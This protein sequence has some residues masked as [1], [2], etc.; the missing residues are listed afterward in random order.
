MPDRRKEDGTLATSVNTDAL[1][2]SFESA[3]TAEEEEEA[4]TPVVVQ[5]EIDTRDIPL[6]QQQVQL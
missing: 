3:A 1:E 6:E 2:D 5:L 4:A